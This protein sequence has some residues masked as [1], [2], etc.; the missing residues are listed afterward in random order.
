MR[1]KIK[2]QNKSKIE[3]QIKKETKYTIKKLGSM[4]KRQKISYKAI[5]K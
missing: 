2:R 3:K 1:S 5:K 4:I